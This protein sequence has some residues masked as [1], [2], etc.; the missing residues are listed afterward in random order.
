[1]RALYKKS[2]NLGSAYLRNERGNVAMIFAFSVI[3]LLL[4][5]GIA[6]DYARDAMIRGRLTAVADAAVLTA[7]TPAMLQQSSS[8]AQAAATKMFA[9][10]AALINGLTYDSTKLT[11]TITDTA[12]ANGIVRKANVTY[13]ATVNNIFGKLENQQQTGFTV[14][15]TSTISSAP[16]INFYLMLDSSPSME[17][18]ATTAG[19]N[20]MVK[21]TGCALACHES[22]FQDSENTVQYPGWGTIDSYTYAKNAGITLRIDNVRTAAQSLVT[23]AQNTMTTYNASAQ[24]GVT[25]TYQM[26]AYTFDEHLTKLLSLTPTTSANASTMQSAISTIAPPLM[27][28]NGYLPVGGSYTYPTGTGAGSYT[29]IASIPQSATTNYKSVTSGKKTT[30]YYGLSNDDAGTNFALAL[31]GMNK[32]MPNPGN[33]T[34]LG[35]DTPQEVLMIVTDGVDDVSLYNSSSCSTSYNWSYTNSYGSFTRCQQPVNT[36]LCTTIKARGIR[37]AVLYTTYFPVTSNSWYNSTVAPFISQVP[38]NL[39]ACASSDQLYAEVST[40]GDITAALNQLFINAVQ[41]APHLIQ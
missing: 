16:N 32:N 13:A 31:Y 2:Q 21:N 34:S 25:L 5:G 4:T 37:I 10:Q 14:A 20:A 17:I 18:P 27:A 28:D 23:T 33:G 36:A 24:S 15:S 6:I 40:D 7:T 8:V 26:A 12:G 38:T 9:A 39:K 11:V 3:P 30:K 22:D 29:T 19:I 1:M 41:S 35:S